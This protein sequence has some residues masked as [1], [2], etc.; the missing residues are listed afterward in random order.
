MEDTILVERRD[1]IAVVAI[2]RPEKRNALR[3]DDWIAVGDALDAL[4]EDDDVRC[5]VLRGA[6][7]EAFCAGADISGFE[8]ERS[9][10]EK[11]RAYG[12]ATDRAFVGAH[13][14]RHPVIAMIHG[15]CLGGG[16]ELALACDLRISGMSGRFG[17][18]AKN[19]G[20]YLSYDL[21]ELLVDASSKATAKEILL[22]GRILPA[23]EA[24]SK[25]LITRVVDDDGLEEE[26][27]Q[28]ARRIA[29]GAP[30]STRWHRQAIRR[31]AQSGAYSE[32][33]LEAQYDYADTEDYK[34]GYQAF[35]DR[36]KP[37]FKGR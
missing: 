7:S 5:V 22:E 35:L 6:G 1:D 17:I 26:V 21:V 3:Q 10:R 31:I 16:F 8:E 24:Q 2:N 14:C 25:N 29:G 23:F 12:A 13:T 19:V 30:L 15:F 33:E 20:L 32:A 36:K 34:A 27:M 18:P 11:V 9:S 37:V 4:G 28:A